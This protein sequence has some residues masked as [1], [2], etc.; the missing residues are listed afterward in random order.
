MLLF[1]TAPP[2]MQARTTTEGIWNCFNEIIEKCGA[3][4]VGET[5]NTDVEQY[6]RE[7]LIPF[8]RANS[9]LCWKENKHCFIQLPH[10]ARHYLVPSPTSVAS[11]RLFSTAGGIHDE[12]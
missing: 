5:G 11:E 1:T 8:H 3:S 6:L 10:L 9:F 12:K 2:P 4:V 7:P